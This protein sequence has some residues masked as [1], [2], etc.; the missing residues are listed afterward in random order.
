MK[1]LNLF[2]FLFIKLKFKGSGFQSSDQAGKKKSNS[3]SVNS[4]ISKNWEVR[5]VHNV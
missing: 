2:F 1:S 3:E 5:L 4:F